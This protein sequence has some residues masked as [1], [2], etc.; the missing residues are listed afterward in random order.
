MGK[1]VYVRSPQRT[2]ASQSKEDRPHWA[3]K[4]KD[5]AILLYLSSGNLSDV[6]RELGVPYYTLKDWKESQWWK[7]KVK[8]Y[9][10]AEYDRID[11]KLSK[12][13]D[14]A[15]DGVVDRMEHGE[16]MYDPKTGKLIKVPAKLRDLNTS[17]NSIMTNRQLIRKQPT[18]IVEQ[19]STA[20]QLQNLADEFRKFVTGKEKEEPLEKLVEAIEGDTVLQAE[21]GTYYIKDTTEDNT[22]DG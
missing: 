3:K 7:D 17:F 10:A 22:L 5:K 8:E 2:N 15:L 12:A 9:Q 14:V 4:V 19:N 18:K 16:N 13:L 1:F 21:D 20:N 11:A 6:G